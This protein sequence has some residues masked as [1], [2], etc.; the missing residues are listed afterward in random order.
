M[1]S[2]DSGGGLIAFVYLLETTEDSSSVDLARS[3][4]SL[5]E[6]EQC[7]PLNYP[8]GENVAL[9]KTDI[10]SD[11]G[12]EACEAIKALLEQ[13]GLSGVVAPSTA[14]PSSPLPEGTDLRAVLLTVE[15]M[16]CQSC[17]KLIETTLGLETGVAAVNVS[18]ERKEAFV[19]YSEAQ[20]NTDVI[21]TV[22]YDMG[23]DVEK[24]M[25]LPAK[26]QPAIAVITPSNQS[27]VAME[28]PS[29]VTLSVK[30]MVCMSCVNNIQT[31]VGAI[32]GVEAVQVSLE[33]C[34][35]TI[36]YRP[37][38]IGPEDLVRAVEELGFEA[39][40]SHGGG[41]SCSPPAT[42][43][44]SEGRRTCCDEKKACVDESE[45]DIVLRKISDHGKVWA[46]VLVC[47]GMCE[48]VYTCTYVCTF[49]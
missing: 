31:N 6:V 8:A 14:P 19:Q 13:R 17:V 12:R 35:A 41:E 2:S 24:V 44:C 22:I 10:R 11:K 40:L 20:T 23:F 9:L 30:G 21:S 34:T 28:T 25:D 42:L 48:C 15:G 47:S 16:T 18:L 49:M 5:P 37:S 43:A 29:I 32:E 36:T 45:P 27:S 3:I 4:S 46:C 39:S 38:V 33:A 1:D 7:V 26:P